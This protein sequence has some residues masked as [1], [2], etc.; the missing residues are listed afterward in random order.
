MDHGLG[1]PLTDKPALVSLTF[2]DGL[3]CQFELAVPILDGYDF[4]ATFFLVAN[5]DQTHTDGY[6]HPD[7]R[8]TNW[9]NEDIQFLK[10]MV[11]RGHEIGAHSVHHRQPH[12]DNDPKSEAEGSKQWIESRLGTSIQSYCYPFYH[13]TQPIKNAVINAGYEQGRGGPGASYYSIPCPALDAFNVD[14]RQIRAMNENV[15]R[16]V[17]S[18]HWHVLTFHGIG[19]I[20][21]GWEPITVA[22]FTRQMADLA[23]LRDSGAVRVVTFQEGAKHLRRIM[24][25]TV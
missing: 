24:A 7:W 21:D 11:K 18:N 3:R 17:R 14:S 23:R 5:A 19:T 1:R 2:D 8:K 12:L 16:W 4:P 15:E 6:A 13:I 25:G 22:E 10:D 20:N 9:C